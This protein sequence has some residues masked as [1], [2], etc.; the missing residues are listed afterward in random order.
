MND[1]LFG[2]WDGEVT[3]MPD[4]DVTV[5]GSWSKDEVPVE[6]VTYTIIYHSNYTSKVSGETNEDIT[7]N[8]ATE[9]VTFRL[10]KDGNGNGFSKSESWQNGNT[11][12]TFNSWNTKADGSGTKFTPGAYDGTGAVVQAEGS[13]SM[14]SRAVRFALAMVATS[15]NG[16]TLELW[17]QWDES[18]SGGGNPS[19]PPRDPDPT[20]DP[21]PTDEPEEPID[22]GDT[23]L[24]PAEIDEDTEIDDG[25]TP[26]AP[27]EV[28]ED[29]EIDE[30][31]T[32]LSPFTGDERHTA[33]WGFVSLLSLAGIV[34]VARKR[35][36]E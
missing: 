2:G 31:A 1:Y 36:E 16:G 8:D 5:I 23:P 12:Y 28:E 34:V 25:D 27:A 24:A 33:V 11:T 13:S 17:A 21:D 22:D 20:P 6:P 29:T 32:P 4:H 18:T 26:L 7:V 9:I 3:T 10:V 35:R 30:E 19:R 14:A 15:S